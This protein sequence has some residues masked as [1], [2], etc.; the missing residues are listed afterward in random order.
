VPDE[1]AANEVF[2]RLVAIFAPYRSP[3]VAR[4]DEPGNLY[5]ATPPS[6]NYP[7]GFDFGAVRIGK[8]Y[9]SSGLMPSSSSG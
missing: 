3:L 9:V 8:R 6:A 1:V 7:E 5:L 4:T 2:T